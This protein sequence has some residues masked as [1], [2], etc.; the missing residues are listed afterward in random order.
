[1]KK[2]KGKHISSEPDLTKAQHIYLGWGSLQDSSTLFP[3]CISD[4]LRNRV[5]VGKKYRRWWWGRGE[6]LSTAPAA[7]VD[8]RL[9]NNT[10]GLCMCFEVYT[11]LFVFFIPGFLLRS[12]FERVQ[13]SLI[14]TNRKGDFLYHDWLGISR[15][16]EPSAV[17]VAAAILTSGLGIVARI[18]A[19]PNRKNPG[20]GVKQ[21]VAT[22]FSLS[23]SSYFVRNPPFTLV[24][25][26]SFETFKY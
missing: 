3:F 2:D 18:G 4:S 14:E 20:Q 7:P 26:F 13:Y 11:F 19:N 5:E 16:S 23:G 6:I 15:R 25:L 22:R 24:H 17:L 21:E 10:H 1:M 12:P 9:L 8:S